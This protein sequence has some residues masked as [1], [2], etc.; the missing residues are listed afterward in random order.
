[1]RTCVC[2][3]CRHFRRKVLQSLK[4]DLHEELKFTDE[5]IRQMPKNYQVW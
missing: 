3:P 4:K 1:M 5:I 2:H